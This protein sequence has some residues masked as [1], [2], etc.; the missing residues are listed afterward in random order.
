MHTHSPGIHY[1]VNV[2]SIAGHVFDVSLRIENP[3]TNGQILTLPAWIPGSYMIRDFAKNIVTISAK[4]DNGLE[5]NVQ[6]SDKQT[7]KVKAVNTAL[8]IKYQVYAF[9]L[10][11]RGAYINDEIA[12]FNGTNMFCCMF[13]MQR[14]L[15]VVSECRC[16]TLS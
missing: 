15:C 6:K 1:Q 10:S 2:S 8:N 16:A 12:F 14:K 7:W 5:I 4:D 13:F 11:V 3:D 9:D